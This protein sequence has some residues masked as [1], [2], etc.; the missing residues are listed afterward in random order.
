MSN[1]NNNNNNINKYLS[2]ICINTAS[3][4]ALG[5]IQ[6]PIQWVPG[7]LFMGVK[8]PGR[9]ANHQLLSS[10]E[11]K[12]AWRYTSN[13]PIRLMEWY[14]VKHKDFTFTF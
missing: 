11:F 4:T 9:E 3:R 2:K 10:A 1:N 6:P 12:E 5:P 8:R 13:R 7:A 14:L